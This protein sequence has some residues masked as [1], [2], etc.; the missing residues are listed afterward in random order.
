MIDYKVL[1]C[2]RE[3]YIQS[4]G[5]DHNGKE[6]FERNVYMCITITWLYHRDWSNTVNQLYAKKKDKRWLMQT[7]VSVSWL[8][9]RVLHRNLYTVR[10]QILNIISRIAHN[11]FLTL[12][13]RITTAFSPISSVSQGAVQ[14]W[15]PVESLKMLL[16]MQLLGLL[17]RHTDPGSLEMRSKNLHSMDHQVSLDV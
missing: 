16:K 4:P 10:T 12:I 13:S 6:Y 2:S 3:N 7:W 17:S 1:L 5:I 11:F 9:L 8:P 15:F 14:E